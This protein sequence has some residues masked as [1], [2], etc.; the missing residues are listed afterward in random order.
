MPSTG[1]AS[2]HIK[3]KQYLDTKGL[4]VGAG[5]LVKTGTILTR[6]GNKWKAGSNVGDSGTLYALCEGRVYFTRR[7]GGLDRKQTHINIMPV[8][9]T[10]AK[11]AA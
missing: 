5:Q 3:S 1:G 8:Q 11:T 2:G 7:K 9:L 4:K 6:Q 10:K